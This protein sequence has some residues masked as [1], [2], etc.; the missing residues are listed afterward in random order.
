MCF[1]TGCVLTQEE[2]VMT[3]LTEKLRLSS[4]FLKPTRFLSLLSLST[5]RLCK[6][7]ARFLL[8][9]TLPFFSMDNLFSDNVDYLSDELD[10]SAYSLRPNRRLLQEDD[11]DFADERVYLLP[12]RYLSSLLT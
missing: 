4:L 5:L 11:R 8:S 7:L 6:S 10:S 1:K 12:Y 9:Q 2:S 3:R